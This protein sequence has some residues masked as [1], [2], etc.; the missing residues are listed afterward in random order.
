MS[1]KDTKDKNSSFHK[2][3]PNGDNLVARFAK[4]YGA[5]APAELRKAIDAFK[6]AGGT[7]N[8]V[9]QIGQ[10]GYSV[11][12]KS[13]GKTIIDTDE[14]KNKLAV[15]AGASSS[16]NARLP[17]NP[18]GATGWTRAILV[19]TTSGGSETALTK[20]FALAYGNG[21]TT[22]GNQILKDTVAAYKQANPGKIQ[23]NGPN[24]TETELGQPGAYIQVMQNGEWVSKSDIV[25]KTL[26]GAVSID[27]AAATPFNKQ[28]PDQQAYLGGANGNSVMNRLN[29]ALGTTGTASLQTAINKYKAQHPGDITVKGT[30]GQPGFYIQINTAKGKISG[31][32]AVVN[33]LHEAATA[34]ATN[35]A[36]I[37]I[38]EAAQKSKA[39]IGVD[40]KKD[41]TLKNKADQQIY[42]T[43]DVNKNGNLT[44]KEVNSYTK[45]ANTDNKGGVSKVE[46]NAFNVLDNSSN[47][48]LSKK[49]KAAFK[50]AID[51]N[52]NGDLS[53]K[54][55]NNAGKTLQ[56]KA[57]IDTSKATQKELDAQ[58]VAKG[59]LDKAGKKPGGQL[60]AI[61]G[62]ALIVSPPN[63]PKNKDNDGPRNKNK[64]KN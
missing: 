49:E 13:D 8:E 9:G 57:Q 27:G 21:N 56:M 24:G 42:A 32:N 18:D 3:D 30:L 43:A 25:S 38:S 7:V 54:E 22:T 6:A 26:A 59:Y 29:L 1:K 51:K 50:Q 28:R 11:S 55:L 2:L 36:D 46:A 40:V 39:L 12:I 14:I 60:A 52:G 5:E 53:K 62:S 44:K 37:K 61:D 4:V 41:G 31:T 58:V 47:G 35:P 20:R 10:Y 19:G 63:K 23:I 17:D 15:H 64:N 34:T 33:R 16:M 45:V 48:K